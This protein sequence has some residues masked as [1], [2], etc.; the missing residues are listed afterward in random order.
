MPSS[1]K[2]PKSSKGN[3]Y[4]NGDFPIAESFYDKEV[5]IPIYPNLSKDDIYFV[6]K[7]I[8]KALDL[9]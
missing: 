2:T 4:K 3:G 8:K 6:I 9:K 5:S 7:S 1:K